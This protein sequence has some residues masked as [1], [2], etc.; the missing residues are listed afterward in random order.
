M[1][2][3]ERTMASMDFTTRSRGPDDGP[4]KLDI[5]MLV[6]LTTRLQEASHTYESLRGDM[7]KIKEVH[8][9]IPIMLLII[10]FLD[11]HSIKQGLHQ[12]F[13]FRPDGD[14]GCN[15]WLFNMSMYCP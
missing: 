8:I 13:R 6:K 5:D 9:I 4:G 10:L 3:R 1:I 11:Y 7:D 14:A 2:E 12:G 15:I